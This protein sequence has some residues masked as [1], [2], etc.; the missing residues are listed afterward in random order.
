VNLALGRNVTNFN[1]SLVENFNQTGAGELCLK[2]SVGAA[3]KAG[4]EKSNLT[5]EALDGKDASLQVIQIAHS[6]S[7]LYNVSFYRDWLMRGIFC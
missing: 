2:D 1:I 3:L 7:A 6:G 4:L 5:E